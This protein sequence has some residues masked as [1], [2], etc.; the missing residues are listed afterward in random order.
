MALAVASMWQ[1]TLGV[2]VNITLKNQEWKTYLSERQQG[3]FE[4]ARASWLAD[5]N[6]AS[7]FLNLLNHRI[8]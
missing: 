2:R 4:I 7:T 6:E 5:Y 8:L 3:S 1:K